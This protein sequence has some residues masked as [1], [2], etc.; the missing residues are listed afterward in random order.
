MPLVLLLAGS[1]APWSLGAV[2]LIV[3]GSLGVRVLFIKIPHASH[4]SRSAEKA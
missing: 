1:G 3:L 2:S 4:E